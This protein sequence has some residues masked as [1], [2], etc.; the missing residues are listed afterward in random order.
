MKLSTKELRTLI[1]EELSKSDIADR[2]FDLI[3]QALKLIDE[4]NAPEFLNYNNVGLGNIRRAL[5]E[6]RKRALS[7]RRRYR[8]DPRYK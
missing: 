5:Q 6:E 1:S 4:A 2:Y 8:H 7:Q 3:D